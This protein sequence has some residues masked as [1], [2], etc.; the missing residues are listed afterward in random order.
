MTINHSELNCSEEI[1]ISGEVGKEKEQD[2]TGMWSA[3]EQG[4]SGTGGL[5]NLTTY[6]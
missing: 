2:C 1:E 5:T 6:E 4:V 3:W